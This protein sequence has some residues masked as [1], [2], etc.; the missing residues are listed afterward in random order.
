MKKVLIFGNSGSGKSTLASRLSRDS[1]LAH[2]DLDT[3]AWLPG[4]PPQR[5]PLEDAAKLLDAF[6]VDNSSWVIEGCYT[7][8]LELL[9]DLAD[10]IIY[11]KLPI[12]LCV[13]NAKNRSWE[14]HKYE[15]KAEQDQNLPM[16]LDWIVQYEERDDVFSLQAH[17][18]FYDNF[19]GRKVCLTDND[20]RF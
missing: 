13:A 7:D 14:S 9:G 5:M 15:S 17:S 1:S 19:A 16:L 8:L 18:R 11:L 4:M 3:L 2:L 12:A 10:E 20:H 6:L